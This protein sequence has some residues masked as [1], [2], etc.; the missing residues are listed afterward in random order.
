MVIVE[1]KFP[2]LCHSWVE[3]M[4][5]VPTLLTTGLSHIM[6]IEKNPAILDTLLDWAMESLDERAAMAQPQSAYKV[7]HLKMG[8]KLA[9]A[10]CATDADIAEKC[11]V[12]SLIIDHDGLVF[13][14][15]IIGILIQIENLY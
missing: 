10:L 15:N 12:S 4:E 3:A 13:E 2:F 9:G 11:L 8:F 1:V 14:I 7:R 6:Y 5:G